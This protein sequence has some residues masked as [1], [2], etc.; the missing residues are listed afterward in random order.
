MRGL[1]SGSVIELSVPVYGYTTEQGA[2]V[3]LPSTPVDE[4]VA[5][6]VVPE[7]A[8]SANLATG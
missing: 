6:F 5:G 1:S 3:L 4:I 8:D 7:T 2:S